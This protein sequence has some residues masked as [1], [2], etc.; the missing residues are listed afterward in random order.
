MNWREIVFLVTISV[1]AFVGLYGSILN[2]QMVNKLNAILPVD[3]QFAQLGWWPDKYARFNEQYRRAFPSDRLM[4]KR[5]VAMGIG[6]ASFAFAAL[7]IFA[8]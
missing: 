3:Q 1:F 4:W 2:I 5:R 7:A 6:V 8:H